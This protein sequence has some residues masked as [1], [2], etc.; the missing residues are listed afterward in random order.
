[1]KNINILLKKLIKILPII[2]CFSTLSS[3][4]NE[5]I[6]YHKDRISQEKKAQEIKQ[7]IEII[8][9]RKIEFRNYEVSTTP[10]LLVLDTIVDKISAAKQKI[11]IESYIFTEKRIL[12]SIIEA[13]KR[14]LD[15]KIIL[16][17][18]VY[19]AWNINKKT[20]ES[21]TKSWIEVK[22][23]N[24]KNYK[25]TH[26]KFFI[27]DDE[28]IISTWNISYSSFKYNKEFFVFWNS[29]NSI[30]EYNILNKIFEEDW[31][32]KKYFEC[33]SN[34]VM[35]PFCSEIG[36]INILSNAKKSIIIYWQ[37][38]NSENIENILIEKKKKWV[39]I[40]ILMGDT[41]KV[42]SNIE[43]LDKFLKNWI[44]AK[45]P[46]KPYIHAKVAIIDE[47]II[48]I[49]SINYTENS[50]KNNREVGLIFRNKDIAKIIQNDFIK[51]FN[52]KQN[53]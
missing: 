43:I 42:N 51:I 27:I 9:N 4:S 32:N 34:F 2:L 14:W 41:K 45:T 40:K 36:I 15:I 1:M 6:N 29:K 28:F 30:T 31:N 5:Y 13:K 17:K 24:N 39:D 12:K 3:C 49:W 16:E 52:S 48:Y 53:K 10:D 47:E 22:Y 11:Y 23:S 33:Y 37:T 35:S 44:E 50:M 7:N 26:S 21:L 25:Y 38:F 8:K 18:N 20:Y 19:W 46:K